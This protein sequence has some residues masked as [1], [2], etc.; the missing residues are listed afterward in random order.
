MTCPHD[1]CQAEPCE[2]A[3]RLLRDD[4]SPVDEVRDFLIAG[5]QAAAVVLVALVLAAVFVVIRS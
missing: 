1:R 2:C 5:A 4:A 3:E